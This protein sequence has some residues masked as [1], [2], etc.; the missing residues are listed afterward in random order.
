NQIS[1]KLNDIIEIAF[2]TKAKNLNFVHISCVLLQM[3]GTCRKTENG[4]RPKPYRLAKTHRLFE[5]LSKIIVENFNVTSND[6]W[7][8]MLESAIDV[9]FKLAD[10]PIKHVENIVKKL[11]AKAGLKL[12][13]QN[14]QQSQT[15]NEVPSHVMDDFNDPILEPDHQSNPSQRT[16]LTDISSLILTRFFNCLGKVAIGI[17][18]YIDC[19]MKEELLRRKDLKE[20]G[21]TNE[22][23]KQQSIKTKTK[24]GKN[25]RTRDMDGD[26]ASM[27]ETLNISMLTSIASKQNIVDEVDTEMDQVFGGAEAEDPVENEIT[28]HIQTIC[29]KNSLLMQ[30]VELI[31]H[32][33]SHQNVYNDELLQLSAIICLCKYMLLSVDLCDRQLHT[34]F[35][36][37]KN[38]SHENVRVTIVVLMNDF[39]LKYPLALASYSSDVYGCLRDRSVNVRLAALKTISNLILKEMVKPKGQISEIAMC[40]IDEHSQI[41][42]LAISFFMELSKRQH[43]DALFNILPDILGNLVGGGGENR[44]LSEEDFERIM[45][46]LF[47]FIHK[48]RHT[49]SLSEKLCQRFHNADNDPRLWRDLAYIMSKLSYNERALKYLLDHYSWYADKLVD[50]K[51][52][53]YFNVILNCGK[54]L[55]TTKPELKVVIDE[56]SL[57]I[58]QARTTNGILI[59]V[60]QAQKIKQKVNAGRGRGRGGRGG[61][62]PSRAVRSTPQRK[63]QQRR[64]QKYSSSSSDEKENNQDTSEVDEKDFIHKTK[65]RTNPRTKVKKRVDSD[66]EDDNDF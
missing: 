11:A 36:L 15:T 66:D 27:N 45:E 19:T 5:L 7:T 39:Y 29:E 51:V 33:I 28:S 50:D 30:Y 18:Y 63:Q 2:V 38:S 4:V 58:E 65:K 60:Q 35:H 55:L 52:Y 20:S 17:L 22:K 37:L 40:I 16:I 57:K 61:T 48:E 46:F 24:R 6:K 23:Q 42:S 13:K 49:E 8:P 9:I 53:E 64:K 43:G 26:E 32:I 34:I 62:T 54:K 44:N 25:K 10:N 1:N 14:Q 47:K 12:G 56:L 59:A 3:I 41:A 31:L 21:K